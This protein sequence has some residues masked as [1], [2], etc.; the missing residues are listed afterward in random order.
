[1]SIYR[2][3]P[4]RLYVK[5]KSQD[6]DFSSTLGLHHRRVTILIVW[7]RFLRR[8]HKRAWQRRNKF[9]LAVRRVISTHAYVHVQYMYL[10]FLAARQGD[11]PMHVCVVNITNVYS[12]FRSVLG[13]AVIDI[14]IVL[15]LAAKRR[16]KP[17]RTFVKIYSKISNRVPR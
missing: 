4:Q 2:G 9:A 16:D 12:C 10:L 1:M 8:A 15:L 11:K 7:M 17:Y 5:T 14:H 6:A 3:F 13:T